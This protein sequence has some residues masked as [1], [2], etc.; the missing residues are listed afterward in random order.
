MTDWI[1]S[2]R[3]SFDSRCIV[4]KCKR[5]SCA[6]FLD[7]FPVN[8]VIVDFDVLPG[9][10]LGPSEKKPD[11]LVVAASSGNAA[12]VAPIEIKG[13]KVKVDVSDAV[14]QLQAGADIAEKHVTPGRA[15][16]I[17]FRPVL[18]GSSIPKAE[19]SALSKSKIRFHG[20]AEVVRHRRC[21]RRLV[22][23]FPR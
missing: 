16:N 19:R 22:D 2:V 11:F 7:D 17:V 14:R 20:M 12:W 4:T 13:S 23:A 9:S 15:A 10:P 1:G 18:T 8:R 21:G 5:S 3:G 6:L